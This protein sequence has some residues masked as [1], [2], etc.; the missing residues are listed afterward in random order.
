MIKAAVFRRGSGRIVD[1]RY[2]PS[3]ENS[4][5]TVTLHFR[6]DDPPFTPEAYSY[7]MAPHLLPQILV[8][9]QPDERD[10]DDR[11]PNPTG[12]YDQD[13]DAGWMRDA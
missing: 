4:G 8:T 2:Q 13:P 1:Y 12:S 7:G 11:K 10:A 6:Q 5:W 3:G 9:L